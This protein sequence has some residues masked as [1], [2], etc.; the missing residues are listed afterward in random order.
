MTELVLSEH[1][2]SETRLGRL[3]CENAEIETALRDFCADLPR[4]DA[5]DVD[6]HQRMRVA[7]ARDQREHRVHRRLV[8]ADEHAAA[9]EIAQVPH[10]ML[11]LFG[12]SQQAV[13]VIAE[14][15]PR[16]GEGGVLGGAD[17]TGAHRRFPRA[18]APPGSRPAAS[19]AASWRHVKSCAPG[20]LEEDLQLAELH[21]D[22]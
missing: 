10:G 20:N 13:G 9:A 7:E 4:R 21:C 8:A 22:K 5:A 15:A 12:E 2:R 11:R 19:G 16:V 1:D 14:Q 17:R 6:V 18:G 3:K